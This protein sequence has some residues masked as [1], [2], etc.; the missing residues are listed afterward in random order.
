VRHHNS[1]VIHLLNWPS[2]S[3]PS[4]FRQAA[5]IHSDWVN[6]IL[7]CNQNQMRLY[8]LC[9]VPRPQTCR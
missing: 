5:Q 3:Q 1:Y 2:I 6:D 9:I 4:T 7:L 8:R